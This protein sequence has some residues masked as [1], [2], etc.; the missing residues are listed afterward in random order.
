M[1]DVGGGGRSECSKRTRSKPKGLDGD[2]DCA[3]CGD[4]ACISIC[5]ARPGRG[6]VSWPCLTLPFVEEPRPNAQ[7]RPSPIKPSLL[8]LVDSL[9]YPPCLSSFYHASHACIPDMGED[10]S[11]KLETTQDSAVRMCDRDQRFSSFCPELLSIF[12][13][14]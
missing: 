1:K 7:D 12:Y 11:R 5:T 2:Q 13:A 9:P 10:S 6:K 3:Q 14:R 8:S 4:T